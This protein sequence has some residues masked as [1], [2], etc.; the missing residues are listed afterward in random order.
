MNPAETPPSILS[1][2]PGSQSQTGIEEHPGNIKEKFMKHCYW[3]GATALVLAFALSVASSPAALAQESPEAKKQREL[4]EK[5]SKQEKERQAKE[6]K[7]K[8]KGVK[9]YL[10]LLEFAQEE[11]QNKP[12]FKNEVDKD[13]LDL[14]GQHAMQAYQINTQRNTELVSAESEDAT[15]KIRRVLYDNPWIQDYV[16]RV[17][18]RLVPKDSDKIYAFRVTYHP[19]PYAYTLSTGTILVSTGMLSLLDNEAQLSYVLGHE[20]AHVHKDHWKTKIMMESGVDE[21]NARQDAKVRR[22]AAIAGIFGAGVGW[23]VSKDA[24]G[25]AA[26]AVI[27]GIAGFAIGSLYNRQIGVDWETVQEDEADAFAL[28]LVMQN[29]YDA[30]EVP[31]VYLAMEDIARLD[32]RAQLG[33]LGHRPRIQERKAYVD[34]ALNGALKDPYQKLLSSGKMVGSSADYNLVMAELKRDNGIEAFRFDMFQMAR[35]NLQQAVSLRTDDVRATFY[36]GRVLRLVGRSKQELDMAEQ[37]L[38]AAVT[39]DQARLNM[40]EVQLQKA[41]LLME[42]KDPDAVQ[43]LKDYIL[44]YQRKRAEDAA[45]SGS[46]PANL[47]TIYDLMRIFGKELKWEPPVS[48]W[49]VPASAPAGSVLV[50]PNPA[51]GSAGLPEAP[52]R[53]SKVLNN[54]QKGAKEVGKGTREGTKPMQGIKKAPTR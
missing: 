7:E 25:A 37:Y 54:T 45:L 20:L 19:I 49:A 47:E 33:F 48:G 51:S 39:Q 3:R 42:K 18:Q 23:G 53:E 8:Q 43:A 24:G 9:K 41:L 5:K 11:Y 14:Q 15:F 30:K 28:N 52:G 10:T 29:S 16:N 12:K 40:P 6:E 21:Y 32:G 31:K 35:R 1:F 34:S 46:T 50:T 13:Y 44:Q 38:K 36:Y 27:G 2:G 4:E 22:I 26:G 17:G